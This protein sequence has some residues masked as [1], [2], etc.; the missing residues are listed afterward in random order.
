VEVCPVANQL[1]A[2]TLCVLGK[3]AKKPK[4][5]VAI[6]RITENGGYVYGDCE[7]LRGEAIFSPTYNH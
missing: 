7:E 6:S 2:G 4:D 3:Y 5:K 1:N